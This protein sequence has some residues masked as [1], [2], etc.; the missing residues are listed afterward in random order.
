VSASEQVLLE[1]GWLYELHRRG[2]QAAPA[3]SQAGVGVR[4]SLRTSGGAP[5]QPR[6]RAEPELAVAGR[7]AAA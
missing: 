7:R 2:R 1:S 6:K 5:A 3:A 4:S